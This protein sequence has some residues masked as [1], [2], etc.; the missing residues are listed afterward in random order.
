MPF[1]SETWKKKP[2]GD[3]QTT[4]DNKNNKKVPEKEVDEKDKD[5]SVSLLKIQIGHIRK[6]WKHPSADRYNG[7]PARI[8]NLPY[9]LL[10]IYF[11]T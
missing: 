3:N 9:L 2:A 11:I 5:F 8:L 4:K 10:N 7:Q 1:V 6:A